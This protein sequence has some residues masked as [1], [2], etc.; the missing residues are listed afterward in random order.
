MQRMKLFWN[1]VL[2]YDCKR[3]AKGLYIFI[4]LGI[5]QPLLMA[6]TLKIAFVNPVLNYFKVSPILFLVVEWSIG[7]ILVRI[8]TSLLLLNPRS[9]PSI[10]RARLRRDGLLGFD[11]VAFNWM[12][13]PQTLYHFTLLTS[14]HIIVQALNRNREIGEILTKPGAIL[15]VLTFNVLA[16]ILVAS[17]DTIIA[18]YKTWRD[19]L[20]DDQFLVGRTLLNVPEL[21]EGLL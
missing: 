12:V 20:I 6:F 13:L 3:L 16:G 1:R 11:L 19:H 2:Y 21:V 4:I 17:S 8:M 15:I 9:R 7:A 14:G 10:I 5:I 18:S